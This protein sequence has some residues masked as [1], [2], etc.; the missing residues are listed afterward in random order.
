MPTDEA[1]SERVDAGD[2][3][4]ARALVARLA[5]VTN[6]RPASQCA[7]EDEVHAIEAPERPQMRVVAGGRGRAIDFDGDE[8]GRGIRMVRPTRLETERPDGT[9]V[10]GYCY[11]VT[12]P[13]CREGLPGT[14]VTF[15]EPAATYF[16]VNPG[17]VCGDCQQAGERLDE[18]E[19]FLREAPAKDHDRP[20][21]E[22]QRARRLAR[23]SAWR[24]FMSRPDVVADR[25]WR[26]Q[27]AHY[28]AA[29][30]MRELVCWGRAKFRLD[31][32]A[33]QDE[34]GKPLNAAQQRVL[35]AWLCAGHGGWEFAQL[36]R[37]WRA[38]LEREWDEQERSGWFEPD[39]IE[40][41]AV[42]V[43]DR[44]PATAAKTPASS[45]QAALAKLR[46]VEAAAE[47]HQHVSVRRTQ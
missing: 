10:L 45:Y 46:S 7:P 13:V 20:S 21:W 6:W 37:H 38:R 4:A 39:P 1:L 18:V 36:N 33:G 27:K 19:H 23:G 44:L 5:A 12:C 17:L 47:D 43:N 2:E 24:A 8:Q 16:F 41:Q 11:E 15:P 25:G 40:Q 14:T 32:P 3:Q 30:M 9:K 34:S 29:K 35:S 26:A 22:C 42:V 28:Y 31:G